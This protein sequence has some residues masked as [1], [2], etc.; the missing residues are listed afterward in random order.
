MP[1]HCL[2]VFCNV[3]PVHSAGWSLQYNHHGWLGIKTK[4][5]LVVITNSVSLPSFVW[6]SVLGT[7]SLFPV[8]F[9]C[10]SQVQ[11][12]SSQF[13][14]DVSLHEAVQYCWTIQS[15]FS[16]HNKMLWNVRIL[17]SMTSMLI[18][19]VVCGCKRDCCWW[20]SNLQVMN[21]DSALNL[22][23]RTKQM[24]KSQ[25]LTGQVARCCHSRL[26]CDCRRST[27]VTATWL[28][29]CYSVNPPVLWGRGW[30][31]WVT[32]AIWNCCN[33]CYRFG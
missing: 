25:V 12:L 2:T 32:L 10:Q 28:S 7:N 19:A 16:D 27:E 30:M 1:V 26:I 9:G 29:R 31:R 23:T 4:L 20:I 33:N 15:S 6:M 22:Q 3:V 14:L 24:N 11:I 17:F 21:I 8:S 18:C 5:L 13:Q